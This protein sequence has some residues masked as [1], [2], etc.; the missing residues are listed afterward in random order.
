MFKKISDRIVG[1]HTQQSLLLYVGQAN[2]IWGKTLD[3]ASK[4]LGSLKTVKPADLK[5]E[6]LI[7]DLYILDD[8]HISNIPLLIQKIRKRQTSARIIVVSDNL[9][10]RKARDAFRAGA[11]DYIQ[12]ENNYRT[13]QKILHENLQKQQDAC[14][15]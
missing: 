15:G 4:K 3:N 14:C 2:P 9:S 12:R 5:H 13:L 10:W 11:I 6:A 1:T 7:H 8:A